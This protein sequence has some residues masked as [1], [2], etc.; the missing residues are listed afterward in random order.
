[1]AAKS[2]PRC[3]V[4]L[5]S[6][7]DPHSHTQSPDAEAC[8]NGGDLCEHCEDSTSLGMCHLCRAPM[9][10]NCDYEVRGEGNPSTYLVETTVCSAEC[11]AA[12]E[13]VEAVDL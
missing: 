10:Y 3:V 4:C 7:P 1:M 2:E 12:L 8:M 11:L 9:C 6:P 13:V 5:R